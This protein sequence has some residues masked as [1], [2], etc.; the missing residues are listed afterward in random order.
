VISHP[1][2]IYGS[3]GQKRGLIPLQDS[4]QCLRLALENPPDVGEYRVF[5][6]FAEVR[7]MKGLAQQVR[8]A[9]EALGLSVEVCSLEN[10]RQEAEEHYYNPDRQHLLDLGYRPTHDFAPTLSTMLR[11]L[12]PWRERIDAKQDV[13]VP[14]VHW[15]GTRRKVAV[16]DAVASS[17]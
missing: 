8:E 14:D 2:T 9:A 15:D 13:L 1:L 3:G 6:Q 5:N 16:L 7:D 11:D 17:F 4:M 12:L 10:P